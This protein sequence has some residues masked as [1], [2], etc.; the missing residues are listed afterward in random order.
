MTTATLIVGLPG[1]A[2]P[3]QPNAHWWLVEDGAVAERGVGPDWAPR[4]AGAGRVVG[5]APA[6]DVRVAAAEPDPSATPRQRSALARLAA[7]DGSLGDPE[8][9]HA[10]SSIPANGGPPLAAVAANSAI[11]QWLDW[12]A[13]AS[14]ELDRIV[15]A[16]ALLPIG[17]QWVSAT[18]GAEH[19]AARG[20]LVIANE[21]A[22]AE[23]LVG[24]SRVREL[25]SVEVDRLIAAAAEAPPLDLRTGRFARRRRLV[26][27]RARIREL[28]V[29]A[30]LI[31]LISL[32]WALASIVRLDS[33]SDRLDQETLQIAEAALGRRVTLETAEAELRQRGVGTEPSF[34]ASITG[35]Y[36]H[37]QPETGVSSTELRFAG[38]GTLSATLAAPTLDPINR[39]LV[40]LQRD[41]YR[42]T[43]VPRQS[44]DG[45]TMVDA[46]VRGTP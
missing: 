26:I 36:Q 5:L 37:L 27:D 23:L 32:L 24:D 21:P 7:L 42:I 44:A 9:L 1:A 2:D 29:L 28:A 38:D 16:G 40:A 3:G 8:T 39:V 12:A 6:A 18:I 14:I 33:A 22:L 31:A 25:D 15:P 35:L 45:R 43:A 34:A 19:L 17:E 41:G 30:A 20:G 46:T 4:A 10:V 13:A 11:L